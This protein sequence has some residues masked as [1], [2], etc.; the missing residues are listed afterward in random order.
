MTTRKAFKA[1]VH[2]DFDDSGPAISASVKT[3][4]GLLPHV[5]YELQALLASSKLD[6]LKYRASLMRK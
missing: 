1:G 3:G 4:S 6:F 5:S 2:V